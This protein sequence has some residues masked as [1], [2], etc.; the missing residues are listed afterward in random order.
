MSAD[1]ATPNSDRRVGD[2]M[3]VLDIARELTV[4]PELDPL[5]GAIDKSARSV[6]GCERVSVFL[7]DAHTDELFVRLGT[8]IHGVRFPANRGIAGAAFRT[9]DVIVV[10]DAYADSRFNP[11][12]DKATGY[13]TRNILT[14]PLVGWDGVPVGVLQAVNKTAGP[15]DAWDEV[16]CRALAAQAGTAIQRQRLLDIWHEKQKQDRELTIA[17]MIQQRQLPVE[18]P[19][20]PGYELAGWNQPAEATGGDFY[21]YLPLPN[22]RLAISLGDAT[23]H[24][25]GPAL[26]TTACRAFARAALSGGDDLPAAVARVN[27]LLGDELEPGHFVTAFFG[28]L[29]P[30]ANRLTY[31]SAG[32]GPIVL[33]RA[34]SRAAAELPTHGPPLG[35]MPDIPFD[36]PE[37]VDLRPGDWL[38]MMT[39]GFYEWEDPGGERF[40]FERLVRVL[41]AAGG[42][43]PAE[44]VRSAYAAV[45]AFASGTPQG[46]DLTAVVVRRTG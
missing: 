39:D 11:A 14:C 31:L 46:D 41:R 15:F 27:R 24:G 2:L 5:L 12:V 6:L 19:R 17:R 8:D 10:P 32:Q 33:Y 34:G 21:D 1:P 9:G 42:S 18:P 35:V 13:V 22:G 16:L 40:G 26:M 4:T 23:G 44:V 43:A 3:A 37:E 30:A 28:I 20:V 36:P 25:V 7:H 38:V 29:D 45:T